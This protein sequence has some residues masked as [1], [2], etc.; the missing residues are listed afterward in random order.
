[1]GR[2]SHSTRDRSHTR[3]SNGA[4][5]DRNS[6]V[7]NGGF[8]GAQFIPQ[9]SANRFRVCVWL[10]KNYEVV[11]VDG[12]QSQKNPADD[13]TPAESVLGEASVAGSAGDLMERS[14]FGAGSTGCAGNRMRRLV[15]TKAVECALHFSERE[16]ENGDAS[17]LRQTSTHGGHTPAKVST[18]GGDVTS[19]RRMSEDAGGL[20]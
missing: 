20:T 8:D 15:S 4:A 14:F 18:D 5:S 16:R 7:F 1:M 2:N 11:Q 3:S 12:A 6:F 17:S 19:R 13:G 10:V 9:D